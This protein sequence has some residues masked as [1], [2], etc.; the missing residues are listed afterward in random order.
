MFDF[1]FDWIQSLETGYKLIDM[2]NKELFRI[3]REIEQLLLTHC[4]DVTN[5]Q[6]LEL[7]GRLRDYVT[8]H[9]YFEEALLKNNKNIDY[10]LHIQ[11]HRNFTAQIN[12][13]EYLALCKEPNEGL[14]QIRDLLQHWIFDH[15][16]HFDI[17]DLDRDCSI[18]S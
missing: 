12:A 10:S 8:Y 5:T 15:I 14:R 16:I 2:Q 3:G 7:I 4:L 17:A 18:S 1:K 11:A 9:F 13:I 6:L